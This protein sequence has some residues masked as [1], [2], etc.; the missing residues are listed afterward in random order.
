MQNAQN[1]YT[2]ESLVS[3]YRNYVSEHCTKICDHYVDE[4]GGLQ[5]I[6]APEPIAG[7]PDEQLL[8]TLYKKVAGEGSDVQIVE[9]LSEFAEKFYYDALTE[10]EMSF[11][12]NRFK[13]VVSYEFDHR[14]EWYMHGPNQCDL[15]SRIRLVKEY[16]KPQKGAKVFIADS[17]YCDLA[18]LFPECIIHGFTGMTHLS[19]SHEFRDTEIW[20]LGQIRLFA[21]GIQSEI[22]SGNGLFEEYSY[23]LPE[24]GSMDAVILRVN[25]DKYFAQGIFGTECKD[26]EALYGLLKPNGK[27]LFFSELMEEMAVKNSNDSY[28][29]AIFDFRTLVV[30]EK[31]VS[32]IVAFE[33]KSVWG[34][35]KDKNIMLEISKCENKE[36]CIKDEAL[37]KVKRIDSS[38]LDPEVLWPSYYWNARQKN[39]VPLSRLVRIEATRVSKE[40]DLAKFVKGKGWT[41]YDK[42]KY[43]PLVTPSLL[44]DGYKD[45]NLDLKSIGNIGETG[46]ET[47]LKWLYYGVAKEP[48]AFLSG[49]RDGI[50][51]GYTTTVPDS[52]IAYTNC[53]C[54]IPQ[55]GVD[56]R[57]IAALLF[58][59]QVQ[60]QISVICEGDISRL[61]YIIDKIMV[62][63]HSDK[64][65]LAF[66]S[67]VNYEALQFSLM[68]MRQEQESYTKAIRMRKHSLTQSLSSIEAMFYA[69]NQYR[70]RQNGQLTDNNVISRVQ[71]TTVKDA[72]EYLSAEIKDMMP[73]LEHIA[74]VEYSF[75]KPE[76]IDPEEFIEYYVNKEKKTWLNFKPVLTWEND[77]NKAKQDIKN[78]KGVVV[79]EKGKPLNTLVFPKDAL[80]KVFNNILS[81]ATAY[82]F[83]D[84]SR[85]DYQ[86]RFSWH[87]DE[88]SLIVEIDNNGTP[89]PEDRDTA[90]LLEYGVSTAL[91][92]DGHNGIG[93]NEIKDIMSRYNGN[94]EIVSSPKDE[95]TVK[96][97]LTFNNANTNLFKLQYNG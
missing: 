28:E 76:S 12:C 75:S 96:Y 20:A 80:E 67:E 93:C 19:K 1:D 9:A 83:T 86:L 57:Y 5:Y 84:D 46:S 44:G 82:A 13:E 17:G 48:C 56:I 49:I 34:T 55:E 33:E 95:F 21:A 37:S 42:V 40:N 50:R 32:S 60:E 16:V 31:A 22:V 61:P 25:E 69:L 47:E 97:I 62:Q 2:I 91:H 89:I 45:A 68:E 74:D 87:T 18:V 88:T 35:G 59:P 43:L 4:N 71:G 10:D 30:K 54:V 53:L 64:E 15:A 36:V 14:K 6:E 27:M 29:K 77:N 3:K 8:I 85:K 78:I 90:S 41:L 38:E 51:V 79:Y 73:V 70:I 66:M 52:G 11:L 24:K 72:F 7:S 65:R 94:L 63:R 81:N 58:E 26:I 23:S 39:G 92:K